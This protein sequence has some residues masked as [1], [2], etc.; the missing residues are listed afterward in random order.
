MPLS[1]RSSSGSHRARLLLARVCGACGLLVFSLS[2]LTPRPY[3]GHIFAIIACYCFSPLVAVPLVLTALVAPA[4]RLGAL[5]LL[6]NDSAAATSQPDGG[7][8]LVCRL[9]QR[10]LGFDCSDLLP[11]RSCSRFGAACVSQPALVACPAMMD[12]LSGTVIDHPWKTAG[13]RSN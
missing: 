13:A 3:H 8:L 1:G 2:H 6:S 10:M 4:Y 11:R 12:L 9:L 7:A 5:A